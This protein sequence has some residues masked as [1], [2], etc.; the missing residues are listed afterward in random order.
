MSAAIAVQQ[1]SAHIPAESA[2]SVLSESQDNL[3][4]RRTRRDHGPLCR[5]WDAW[6]GSS[7]L[8][9]EVQSPARPAGTCPSLH[10]QAELAR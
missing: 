2:L 7:W 9:T 5:L 1:T 6:E 4:A 3:T 10:H 8:M